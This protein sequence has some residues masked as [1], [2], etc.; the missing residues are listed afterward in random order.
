[1]TRAFWGLSLVVLL[2]ACG[3]EEPSP[4]HAQPSAAQEAVTSA[5]ADAFPIKIAP[6]WAKLFT[7]T[8][9]GEFAEVSVR[10]P[11]QSE[12]SGLRYRL[13]QRGTPAPPAAEGVREVEVPLRTVATTSTTELPALLALG[14]EERWI[15]HSDPDFVSS[16]RLRALIEAGR[17]RRIG[18]PADLETLLVLAPDALFADFLT[19]SELERLALVEKAGTAVLVVPSFL[20]QAPLGRAEWVL[21]LSMFL[22]RE[23][24]AMTFFAGIEER[25]L[26]LR[27][28]VARAAG[29]R[30][31]VFTGGPYQNI[32]HVPGGQSFAARLLADAGA[33]YLWQDDSSTG[34]LPLDLEKVFERAHD[35]DFWL[36]PSHWRSLREIA[37][38]DIR[39]SR[40]A[41]WQ[42]GQVIGNDLH[43]SPGGGNDFWEQGAA[44]PDLVLE[45]LVAIFHPGL[46][47]GA[48]PHFHRRLAETAP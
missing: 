37:A 5:S 10:A 25:Y 6:R 32:W 3:K 4:L 21:L 16:P 24:E 30:P 12:G 28:R 2:V 47:P 34:V 1:M 45:D 15:G 38:V 8:Y 33:A 44:R 48:T 35:A 46:L 29:P 19:A 42:R 7:V 9:Q 17:V 20:E 23:R 27:D 11:W 39:L 40:F 18:A 14:V 43:L 31:S 26:D 36:Y 41:A 13:R 22:G